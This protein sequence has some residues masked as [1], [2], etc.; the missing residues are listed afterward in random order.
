MARKERKLQ[1]FVSSTYRDLVDERQA[2][3]SAILKA[4]H[5]PAGM[6]L[7]TAGDLSQMDTIKEWI[8][9]SDV[10]VLLLGGRYGSVEPNTG[11]SYTELEYDYAVSNNKPVFSIVQSEESIEAKLRNV[12][13]D[14]I[15]LSKPT[16]LKQFRAKVLSRISSFFSD[17]KDVRL[18]IY[19]SLAELEKDDRVV[20]WVRAD[21]VPDQ[22][23]INSELTH[24]RNENAELRVDLAKARSDREVAAKNSTDD[25]KETVR[26]LSDIE[27]KI[28]A[29][30]TPNKEEIKTS[31]FDLSMTNKDRLINGI[32]NRADMDEASEFLYFNVFPKLQLHGL[33]DNERVPGMQFRRSFLNKAGQAIFAA[34]ERETLRLAREH[35][36]PSQLSNSPA[37]EASAP[38]AGQKKPRK[39]PGVPRS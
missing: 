19:E 18:A 13:S 39:N 14:V 6:E 21:S 36:Q 24:L 2:A 17:E 9:A 12:G 27:I 34:F 4:G 3:V 1:I 31:L 32:S 16:E 37:T 7:F 5:I 15:E 26:T 10:Y 29:K 20:G 33:S 25:W 8:D 11:L 38:K 28:P 22:V 30:L 35:K 23:A